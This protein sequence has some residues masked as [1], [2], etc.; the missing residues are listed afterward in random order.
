MDAIV[1]TYFFKLIENISQTTGFPFWFLKEEDN[2]IIYQSQLAKGS[3]IN[4]H[5]YI[6][7]RRR[8]VSYLPINAKGICLGKIVCF[9]DKNEKSLQIGLAHLQSII[10]TLIQE[11]LMFREISSELLAN[12]QERNI[13]YE[14]NLALSH[15]IDIKEIANIIVEYAQKAI[16]CEKVSFLILDEEKKHYTILASKGLP[17]EIEQAGEIDDRICQMVLMTREPLLVEDID[18][19]SEL[20]EKSKGTYKTSS[21]LLLPFLVLPV[22]FKKEIIGILNLSDKISGEP[23]NTGDI[24]LCSAL[25]SQAGLAIQNARFI[26][27]LDELFYSTI[28]SLSSAIDAK[29]PYTYG[30][31]QRVTEYAMRT[32]IKMGLPKSDIKDIELAGILHDIGKIGIPEYIL[33]KKEPLN[34]KEYAIIQGHSVRG[35]KIIENIRQLKNVIPL[36]RHHHER[37]DGA[38]YPDGLEGEEIPLGSSILFVADA[39]DAMT[40]DRPYR[41]AFFP[42]KAFKELKRCQCSQFHPD[43]IEAFVH[44]DNSVFENVAKISWIPTLF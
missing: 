26:A 14:I 40:S 32:A 12:Y 8:E 2:S 36:I 34:E 44:L 17:D 28:K 21:F 4:I 38:G 23:F 15:V 41:S 13:F 9:G 7:D 1:N 37:M 20:K 29:D 27:N 10:E 19:Y 24:K 6:A 18:N 31:S 30:H 16:Q 11:T 22:H 5:R 3:K 33:S 35:V 25:A 43:V 39:Y 42:E